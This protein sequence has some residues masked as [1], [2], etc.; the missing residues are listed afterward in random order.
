MAIKIDRKVA[1]LPATGKLVVSGDLHGNLQ[2]FLCMEEIFRRLYERGENPYLLFLGDLIHGQ[3]NYTKTNWP[4]WIGPYYPDESPKIVERLLE[5]ES[6]FPSRICCL[7]GNHE[8]S[9]IGGIW[10]EK[11]SDRFEFDAADR[12]ETFK[13]VFHRLPLVALT[14]CGI[15]FSHACPSLKK[16]FSIDNLA[17]VSYEKDYNTLSLN[18]IIDNEPLGV[19][20]WSRLATY[21][22]ANRFLTSLSDGKNKYSISICGH[23]AVEEGY[24][25]P[26]ANQL[27]LS[28]SYRMQQEMKTYLC[29]DL[30]KTYAD[31]TTLRENHELLPLS[32]Q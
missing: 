28:T 4:Q 6:E 10:L 2:D 9:Q 7:L 23:D 16:C 30:S 29:L 26:E 32:S 27:V 3:Y 11:F 8:H 25:K 17:S 20:T 18:E 12:L 1:H 21:D 14:P 13:T 19:L 15:V 24:D 5:L 31:V 22:D